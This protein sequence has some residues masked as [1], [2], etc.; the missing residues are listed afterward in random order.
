MVSILFLNMLSQPLSK[1]ITYGKASA[2]KGTSKSQ[3]NA[4]FTQLAVH[5]G[6]LFLAYTYMHKPFYSQQDAKYT[7]WMRLELRIFAPSC[8][9][10]DIRIPLP[11]TIDDRLRR[12]TLTPAN[13]INACLLTKAAWDLWSA[14]IILMSCSSSSATTAF[15]ARGAQSLSTPLA[16]L[17]SAIRLAS[18]FRTAWADLPS[19]SCD[20]TTTAFQMAQTSDRPSGCR[21]AFDS[22]LRPGAVL[23]HLF[24][25]QLRIMKKFL[26][27][28]H[29]WFHFYQ[30]L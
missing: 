17:F 8:I 1:A 10:W 12:P 5:G 16:R 25:F 22:L 21:A 26:L 6:C 13:N 18:F 11:P 28:L 4:L 27:F 14:S 29:F 23:D 15:W 19:A 2:G 3:E 7:S 9:P 30:L 20:S 24:T